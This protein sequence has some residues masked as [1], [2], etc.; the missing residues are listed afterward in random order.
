[1]RSLAYTR[2][3]LVRTFR[4]WRLL[5]FSLA[6]PLVLFFMIAAPNRDVHNFDSSGISLPLYYMIG[7]V[8]FGAM[9]SLISTGARI[10]TE[11]TDGWT[12]QL[13]ITP[14][15]PGAYFRAKVLTGYAMAG[16]GMALLYASGISIGVS[17]PLGRWLEM[18]AL[19]LI[20]LIPFA[21]L[22][23]LLGHLATADSIGPATGGLVSLLA[24]VSGTWFPLGSH[25]IVHDLAQFLPSYWLVGA[26]HVALGGPAWTA[27]GWAVIA[28]WALALVALA[29]FA[30]RRDTARV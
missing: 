14:L 7:L 11:R 5:V 21:A 9:T 30:Y 25:G 1:M 18:T 17:L 16:A 29:R 22:G 2:F 27:T 12:R 19:I 20:A 28:V 10:A 26:S 13:R 24:L 4:N 15:R 3:E 23:V 6:F 8:S